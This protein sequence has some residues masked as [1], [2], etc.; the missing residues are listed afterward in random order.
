MA[1]C[2]SSEAAA[3]SPLENGSWGREAILFV[4]MRPRLF[5][6]RASSRE[7]APRPARLRFVG[8]VLELC[9]RRFPLLVSDRGGR[10]LRHLLHPGGILPHLLGRRQDQRLGSIDTHACSFRRALRC[11][12]RTWNAAC[13]VSRSM[14]MDA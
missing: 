6:R 5:T 9:A 1:F 10:L 12:R 7:P 8:L 4:S 2:P 11:K 14:T 13:E 3:S